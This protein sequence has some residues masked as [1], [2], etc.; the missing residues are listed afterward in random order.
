M[1]PSS[2]RLGLALRPLSKVLRT[3]RDAIEGVRFYRWVSPNAAPL[4]VAVLKRQFV[5]DRKE[6]FDADT[7]SRS[8]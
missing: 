8:E 5:S 7:V 3:Y 6:T 4:T 1:A 2:G